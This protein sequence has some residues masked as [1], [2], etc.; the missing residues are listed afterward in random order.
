MNRKQ[1]VIGG[2][3]MALAAGAAA[4]ETSNGTSYSGPRGGYISGS[5]ALS[6][7]SRVYFRVVANDQ[8]VHEAIEVIRTGSLNRMSPELRATVEELSQKMAQE[9]LQAE[10]IELVR[11]IAASRFIEN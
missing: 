5:T 11:T 6:G 9:G 1:F 10:E 3:L 2:L 4:Y 8:V 7:T